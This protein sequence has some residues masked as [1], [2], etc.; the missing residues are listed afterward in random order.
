M[1]DTVSVKPLRGKAFWL[2]HVQRWQQSDLS[3][4]AYCKQHNL[5]A[6]NFYNWS[7]PAMM[8]SLSPSDDKAPSNEHSPTPIAFLP[9]KVEPSVHDADRVS[10][11]RGGTNVSLP[12]DLESAQ[13]QL[14]LSA[15]HQLHV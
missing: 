15:I 11:K 3:K 7:R 2:N 5:S 1:S 10:V 9:L 6:G 12:T 13:L 4:A 14:W 8:Q